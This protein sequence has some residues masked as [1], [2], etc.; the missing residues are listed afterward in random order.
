MSTCRISQCSGVPGRAPSMSTCQISQC[1]D[2]PGR[3]PS[4]STCRISQCSGVPG[5]V[6]IMST[7]PLSQC[8]GVPGRAPGCVI[9]II[10]VIDLGYRK[11]RFLFPF[12][13][14]PYLGFVLCLLVCGV[15][16][17]YLNLFI[18]PIMEAVFV[19]V[20]FT[21]ERGFLDSNSKVK[22]K[23][24]VDLAA[25][26]VDGKF[27]GRKVVRGNLLAT[28]AGDYALDTTATGHANAHVYV[29]IGG[30]TGTSYTDSPKLQDDARV[31][32]TQPKD[33]TKNESSKAVGV[34]FASMFNSESVSKDAPVLPKRI[35]FRTLICEE[36]LS[37]HDTV[38]PKAAKERVM[39]RYANTLVGYFVGKS[40]AFQLVQNYV[41][42][43]WAKFSLSKL[44]KTDNGVFLFKFYTKRGMDQVIER[45]TWLIRNTPLIL[46]KWTPNISLKPGVVTKLPVWVKL[47]NVPV[48]A[49]LKDELSLITTQIGKPIMLDAFT[50]SMCVDSWGQ[51]SFARAIIEIDANSDLKKEVKMAIS[52]NEDD[53]SGYNSEVIRVEYECKPPHCLDCKIFGHNFEKCPNKVIVTDDN[54]DNSAQNNDGFTEV[55][56]RKNKG[57]KVVNQQPKNPIAGLRFHKL[58]SMFFRPINKKSNDKQDKKKPTDVKDSSSHACGDKSTLISNAFSMLNSEEGAECGDSF[59]TN[60]AR[61]AQNDGGVQNPSLGTEEAV[62]KDSLWSKFKAAKEASKSNPISTSDFEEEFDEDEVYFPNEEYTSARDADRSMNG[63]DS[64]NSGMGSRRTELLVRIALTWW[65]SDVKTIAHDVVYAMTWKTLKKM[66]TDKYCSRG[67]IKK[68]EIEMWNMKVKGT[69]VDATEFATELMDKKISTL[70]ERQAENKMKLDNNNQAQQQPPKKQGVAIAYIDGSGKRKEYVGTLP[71]CNK[72]KIHHN[73]QCTVKCANCKRVGHLTRDCRSPAATNNQRNLTCYECGNQGQYKSDCS[74]FKNQNYG[75]QAG[76]TGA[77]GMVHALGGGETNQDLNDTE[78]DIKA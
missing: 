23:N 15:S 46:T 12:G 7:W 43:T 1:S 31:S 28:N 51:I 57:K 45:G 32:N 70:A 40:L 76:G 71:L 8:S 47:Y 62:E 2:V 49:Y 20:G 10:K 66:M 58:K 30:I 68:L 14:D 72:C 34:S 75:N 42:N 52:G 61:S 22:D 9:I 17:A 18:H 78:D 11:L 77:W 35:N 5:R 26:I 16:R 60:D 73:G 29:G 64:H 19:F 37:N 36:Q 53:E 33:V 3:A 55:V 44:M 13:V 65:N 21:N 67:D 48:V 27:I 63:N 50:I 38:L 39:L 25:K 54:V 56:S 4:M 24:K 69:D 74:R 41:N 6:P 59:P